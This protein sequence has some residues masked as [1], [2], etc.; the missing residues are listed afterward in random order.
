M[1]WDINQAIKDVDEALERLIPAE[2]TF[3]Q[4]IHRAV[5]YSVF[6][7]GKRLRP[8][9][10]LAAAEIFGVPR[11]HAL[12][13][14]CAIEMVHTYS[15]IHDDL[16]ALDD[17]DYRR[18]RLSNHKVFGDA[19]AILAGD[20]LLT[21][22]FETLAADATAYFA[23]ATVVRLTEAL[24][25]AAGMSGMIG[26]QVVDLLSEGKQ[27]NAATLDYIHRHKTGALFT[28]CI[29]SGAI[30]GGASLEEMQRLTVFAQNIGLAFQVVDDILDIT[31]DEAAL[32]KKTGADQHKQKATYPALYGLKQ[33][34]EKARDLL[35]AA[36]K[37]ME[38]FGDAGNSLLFLAKKL[39]ER[40]K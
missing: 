31:G 24:G 23:P 30:M 17:D 1:S 11:L 40:E 22:A 20:S 36:E 26:G 27:V 37:E 6:A 29:K 39:V 38:Y 34:E 16:P 33:A 4:D 9:L 10:T 28:C 13:A 3:P 15:L 7:G 18:G 21:L 12:P 35:S 32:G 2:D 14:A 8:L 5:R 19:M 25:K